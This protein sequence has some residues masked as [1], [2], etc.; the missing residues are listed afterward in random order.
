MTEAARKKTRTPAQKASD[1]LLAAWQA[2]PRDEGGER[3]LSDRF[4][5]QALDLLD[6]GRLQDTVNDLITT[7]RVH[8]FNDGVDLNFHAQSLSATASRVIQ[9]GDKDSTET[10]AFDEYHLVAMSWA[11]YARAFAQFEGRQFRQTLGHALELHLKGL[12]AAHSKDG[13]MPS[14]ALRMPSVL[15][16]P[17][18]V[19]ALPSDGKFRLIADLFDADGEPEG[20]AALME[21]QDELIGDSEQTDDPDEIVISERLVLIGVAFASGDMKDDFSF[22]HALHDAAQDPD[23]WAGATLAPDNSFF[24]PPLALNGALIDSLCSHLKS[25]LFISLQA[26]MDEGDEVYVDDIRLQ[27]DAHHNM[28][29]VLAFVDEEEVMETAIPV[30]WFYAGGVSSPDILRHLLDGSDIDVDGPGPLAVEGAAGTRDAIDQELDA[31]LPSL[32]RMPG[33]NRIH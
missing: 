23:S 6:K 13:L 24:M 32:F 21:L 5:G 25:Q 1:A 14:F 7:G 18:V 29:N 27:Y 3:D 28:M 4:I 22:T 2:C 20:F 31:H 17:A 30:D 8:D 26:Q 9:T 10:P 11:G 15:P 12:L 33:S 19:A 16:H